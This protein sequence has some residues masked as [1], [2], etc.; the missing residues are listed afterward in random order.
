MAAAPKHRQGLVRAAASL[1]RRQGYAGTGTSQILAVSGAPRG[2]LYH[3]FP[4]GKQQIAQAAVEYA[5]ELVTATL[6]RLI[7]HEPTPRAALRE[8]GRLLAGWLQD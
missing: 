3:D 6:A 5:G 2:S 1:F 8:Y 4:Q 7:E